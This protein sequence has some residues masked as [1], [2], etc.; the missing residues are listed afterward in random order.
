M[1]HRMTLDEAIE[2]AD[3]VAKNYPGD[4]HNE[5]DLELIGRHHQVA[6]WL[7]ELRERR[8]LGYHPPCPSCRWK[9][10]CVT[11]DQ[12]AV[13]KDWHCTMYEYKGD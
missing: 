10:R 9:T 6:R 8:K 1:I 2:Y 12:G 5:D 4:I 7:T 11:T 3:D 13:S